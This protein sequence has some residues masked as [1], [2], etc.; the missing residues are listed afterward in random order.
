MARI[1]RL[2]ESGHIPDPASH[3]VWRFDAGL[4]RK[5]PSENRG[6]VPIDDPGDG[7]ASQKNVGDKPPI[8]LARAGV[9]EE[10]RILVHA[11]VPGAHLL[12]PAGIVPEIDEVQN[13][14]KP[15]LLRLRNEKVDPL[16]TIRAVV[17]PHFSC[18]II[19]VKDVGAAH[20]QIVRTSLAAPVPY[21]PHAL[22]V[23]RANDRLNESTH[24]IRAHGDGVVKNAFDL[25]PGAVGQIVI[26]NPRD[27]ESA[28]VEDE[29]RAFDAHE[30]RLRH[31]CTA[32]RGG[33]A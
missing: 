30:L 28:S 11:A 23:E 19:P 10:E 8:V 1:N 14:T 13:E 16:E 17:Y 5:L 21:R 7:V 12:Y 9:R 24:D 6:V 26:V 25:R 31:G 2:H 15:P 22:P 3:E 32:D 33:A 27:V 18:P 20:P 4:V 29:V